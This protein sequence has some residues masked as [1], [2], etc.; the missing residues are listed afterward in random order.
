MIGKSRALAVLILLSVSN[1]AQAFP[2]NVYTSFAPNGAT[3]FHMLTLRPMTVPCFPWIVC[4]RVLIAYPFGAQS[5]TNVATPDGYLNSWAFT[6]GYT[7]GVI[8]RIGFDDFP[9][10]PTPAAGGNLIVDSYWTI[11]N[12]RVDHEVSFYYASDLTT[13]IGGVG[14]NL[15]VASIPEPAN[16]AMMIA[17]FGLVGSVS[18]RRRRVIA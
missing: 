9:I 10:S 8:D 12:V 1:R 18:R 14:A 5:E 7:L 4:D 15:Y 2:P 11:N 3:D 13:P 6:N 16:W 17:G